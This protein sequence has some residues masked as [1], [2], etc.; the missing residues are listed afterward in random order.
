M[1][2]VPRGLCSNGHCQHRSPRDGNRGRTGSGRR[3]AR[4]NRDRAADRPGG[5]DLCPRAPELGVVP[6]C[7]MQLDGTTARLAAG[8]CFTATSARSPL[9]LAMTDST[10]VFGARS[11]PGVPWEYNSHTGV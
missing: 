7:S 6:T 11:T 2:Y 9:K 10:E 5:G 3:S 1:R 8:C 4:P